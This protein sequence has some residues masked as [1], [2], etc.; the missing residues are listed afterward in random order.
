MLYVGKA[1]SLR[2]RMRQYTSGQDEREKIPL[3]MEQVASF[4]YVVTAT[5]VESLVL[6]KNLIRQFKPP[7]NVDYRDDKSYPFI[8]LTLSDPFPAIKFTR[9]KHKAGHALLRS[10]HRLRAP[11]ARRSTPCAASSRSAGPRATSGSGSTTTTASA[12]VAPASTRTSA[13]VLGRASTRAPVRSTPRTSARIEGFLAGK[14]DDLEVE[15]AHRMREAAADLDFESA[16][17]YRNRLEA[18]EAIRGSQKVVSARPL[19]MDVVGFFREETVAGVHLFVVREGRVLY[20]NEFVLDK[21]LD[22]S[23]PELVDGFLLRYYADGPQI[24]REI[25]LPALPEDAET[26]EEWLT[27]LRPER[28]ARV[29][30]TGPAACRATRPARLSPRTTR[31]TR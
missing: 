17:R 11:H 7:Y 13:S 23:L 3:M 25:V 9:E 26:V 31:A 10:L 30:L 29:R 20:G 16:A 28:A 15:L 24:P 27:S 4:D 19:D 12:A 18:V 5:E 1:K 22:V 6:E 14:H 8:A 2:K 21:G